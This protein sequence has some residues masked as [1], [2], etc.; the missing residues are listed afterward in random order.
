MQLGSSCDYCIKNP[1]LE[2]FIVHR[3]KELLYAKRNSAGVDQYDR[4]EN[5]CRLS[6]TVD[7]D[8]TTELALSK[9]NAAF[10]KS[11][12][13]SR[14]AMLHEESQDTESS[15]ST[16]DSYYRKAMQKTPDDLYPR[17]RMVAC[18]KAQGRCADAIGALKDQLDIFSSDPEL[19][20]ELALLYISQCSFSQAVFPFE[21]VLLSDPS[22]FYNLLV[23]AETLASAGEWDLS[24]K[25]FCKS[26]QYRPTE[27]RALWGLL[28]CLTC[29]PKSEKYRSL[30]IEG[31]KSRLHAIYTPIKT[32]TAKICLEMLEDVI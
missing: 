19:W 17:K 15:W 20:H 1:G 31:C 32:E 23:Y 3:M 2:N 21:E 18:L 6:I 11:D 7:D 28:T 12:R 16:V 26:L 25:Y 10:P 8:D 9:L 13:V 14:L 27:P 29:T 30:L 4:Y 22:S 24:R 5:M